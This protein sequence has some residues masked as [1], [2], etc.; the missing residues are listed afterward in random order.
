[1]EEKN[2]EFV[3]KKKE[4]EDLVR[5]FNTP[6]KNSPLS[7]IAIIFLVAILVG[8]AAGYIL[9]HKKAGGGSI[10]GISSNGSSVAVGAIV[11]SS[12]LK[13]F[14]DTAQGTLQVGGDKGDGAYHLV[15]SGGASQYVYLTSSVLD[16]SQFVNRKIKVWGQTQKAQYAPW[17]MDVGRVQVL[18]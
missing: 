17:L 11:G 12:D 14:N 5:N 7:F 1:M 16:L 18:Q 6:Q 4:E 13:T 3:V 9:A 8:I 15:R 2:D 10:L